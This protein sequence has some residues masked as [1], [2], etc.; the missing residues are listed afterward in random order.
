MNDQPD[1]LDPIG[2]GMKW[3]TNITT[4]A[5]MMV[6]PGLAGHWLDERFGTSFLVLIGFVFGLT[7]GVW[8]LLKLTGD[9]TR[10]AKSQDQD[11]EQDD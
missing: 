9:T 8:Y 7:S 10:R 1:K 4:A 5:L 2:E 6:L 11:K 3:A